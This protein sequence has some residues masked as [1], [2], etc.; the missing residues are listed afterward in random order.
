M[1]TYMPPWCNGSIAGQWENPYRRGD[2]GGLSSNLSGGN[3]NQQRRK[4]ERISNHK[5]IPD[6]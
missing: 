6:R 1:I 5:E 3:K 4:D 2:G